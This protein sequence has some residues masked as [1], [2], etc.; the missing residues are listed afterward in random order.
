[1]A[2]PT[3]I[4]EFQLESSYISKWEKEYRDTESANDKK[5]ICQLEWK[6]CTPNEIKKQEPYDDTI[7]ERLKIR[8]LPLSR[9]SNPKHIP[10]IAVIK[11]WSKDYH[12]IVPFSRFSIPAV[13]G[14][15]KSGID[16]DSFRVLEVWNGM[17][18][19]NDLIL[20]SWIVPLIKLD[21]AVAR[22]AFDLFRCL[23][24][25]IP[26]SSTFSSQL[27]P[28]LTS[29]GDLRNSYLS[30]EKAQY[31]PLMELIRDR[32]HEQLN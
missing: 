13:R 18:V 12:L 5:D 22:D 20:E 11:E 3:R 26:L 7:I 31:A 6:Q 32:L 4:S 21:P 23:A 10:Y 16:K 14:E 30:E 1:M 8:R 17:V 24:T 2:D 28:S 27:G 29:S 9:V 19:P 25:N 15:M